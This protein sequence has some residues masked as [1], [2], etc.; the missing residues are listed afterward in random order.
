[1]D[2][3]DLE[4]ISLEKEIEFIKDYLY[5][6][7]KLRFN[8]KLRYEV[9]I[10]DDIEED[11]MGVPTMIVQPYVE[12]AIEHGLRSLEGGL[13]RVEFNLLDDET[14]LCVV[15]DNG[16]GREKARQLQAQDV[17]F[18]NHKSKGTNITE[19]R[20]QILHH[21]KETDIFVK[22]IDLHDDRTGKALGTRVEIK[23]PIVDIHVS[24]AES[25]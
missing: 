20:L 12:N 15:E 17:R 10:D 18:H 2:Y 19:K 25:L 23:I 4:I 5:I 3:S 21:A 14:I 16:I 8:D 1:L 9:T 11:I 13:I 22:T 24:K 7:Q 6:N